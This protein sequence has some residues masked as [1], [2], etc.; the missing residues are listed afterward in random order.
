MA[1]AFSGRLRPR[2]YTAWSDQYPPAW[3][4]SGSGGMLNDGELSSST[5]VEFLNAA[6]PCSTML[7]KRS[8]QRVEPFQLLTIKV[9][10]VMGI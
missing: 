2:I 4:V 5:D 9:V 7:E 6:R 8:I 1:V 10:A 3:E